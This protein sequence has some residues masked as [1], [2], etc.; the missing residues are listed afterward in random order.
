MH[1]QQFLKSPWEDQFT[2]KTL[3]RGRSYAEQNRVDIV[4]I[5]ESEIYA[6]CVGSGGNCYE[7]TIS[8]MVPGAEPLLDFS[9]SCPMF[10]DCKHCAAVMFYLQN[11]AAQGE[12]KTPPTSL[13]LELESWINNFP[14]PGG[15]REAYPANVSDRLL[16][17]LKPAP[18]HADHWT[19][20]LYKGRQLKNGSLRDIKS[21]FAVDEMLI[22]QPRHLLESDFRIARLLVTARS[23]NY[24]ADHP[25]VGS[26]G[27]DILERAVQ[28]CRAFLDFDEPPLT[29]GEVRQGAFSW[30]KESS[31]GYRGQWRHSDGSIAQVIALEPLYY[32]DRANRKVG[33]LL[34]D[35]DDKT[36]C[37]ITLAPEVPARMATVLSH[38]IS[39]AMLVFRRLRP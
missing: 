25:L 11:P 32:L 29:I 20:N 35:F 27:A 2:R 24:Y 37:H 22:R 12:S 13:N 3:E 4:E 16:Y 5:T 34:H 21:V 7:Q 18:P 6:T 1:L 23:K 36:A 31:G 39:H 14:D 17:K 9:C 10:S 38:Q 19:L 8:L 15:D 30:S 26:M 28:T 33:R